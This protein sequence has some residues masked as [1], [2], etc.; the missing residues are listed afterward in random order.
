MT[1]NIKRIMLKIYKK[2][3]EV[4]SGKNSK[5]EFLIGDRYRPYFLHYFLEIKSW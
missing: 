1:V 3:N 5:I 4:E 2:P